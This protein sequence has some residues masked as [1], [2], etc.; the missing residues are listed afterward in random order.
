M[1]LNEE[2]KK[3]VR[4]HMEQHLSK[5]SLENLNDR[6]KFGE[7]L[8]ETLMFSIEKNPQTGEKEKR[9][10]WSGE[11][12]RKIDL[13]EVSF[14][15]VQWAS[16]DQEIDLSGTNAVI[17]FSKAIKSYGIVCVQN[18]NFNGVDLSNSHTELI[19]QSTNVD[20]RNTNAKFDLNADEFGFNNCNLDNL[21]LNGIVVD[22]DCFEYGS[23][24]SLCGS[25]FKN[26][27]IKIKLPKEQ[28]IKD[29]EQK[30]ENANAIIS[31]D[32]KR[33]K[34]T[35][36]HLSSE[37]IK[38]VTVITRTENIANLIKT[39]KL[40]GCYVNETL[41]C[42]QEQKELNKQQLLDE[43]KRFKDSVINKIDQEF[44]TIKAKNPA[45][46]LK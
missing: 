16:Q 18:V 44:A 21:D 37:E 9:I 3:D 38:K 39:S 10:R 45:L 5:I 28:I 34:E 23:K 31:A 43:Y 20:Y 24:K 6:I 15:G 46:I 29:K 8:I 7:D 30:T 41:I 11:F 2:G 4:L 35:G 26:T 19:S 25:S 36:K 32:N 27:G 22:S 14:D 17:D 13:S 33:V 1:R 40:D 12:L 42:T